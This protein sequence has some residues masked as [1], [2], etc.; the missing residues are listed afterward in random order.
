MYFNSSIWILLRYLLQFKLTFKVADEDKAALQDVTIKIKDD[1]GLIVPLKTNAE[2]EVK[3]KLKYPAGTKLTVEEVS[4]EGYVLADGTTKEITVSSIESE[5]TIPL[6]L[7]IKT[8]S[9]I[10]TTLSIID[11]TLLQVLFKVI[12]KNSEGQTLGAGAT[13]EVEDLNSKIEVTTTT[14]EDST[15]LND[16]TKFKVG[17]MVTITVNK[18]GY[19]AKKSSYTFEDKPGPQE[20]IVSLTKEVFGEILSCRK[21]D[22]NLGWTSYNLKTIP[23]ESTEDDCKTSCKLNPDCDYYVYVEATKKCWCGQYSKSSPT[24]DLNKLPALVTLKY[25]K[26]KISTI[27]KLNI[28]LKS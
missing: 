25:K 21:Q 16:N 5:R 22:N 1:E 10:L 11:L 12:I 28:F 7:N 6:Q 20:L 27:L 26:G 15:T 18:D 13:V 9:L 19:F 3:T 17:S 23:G 8:V 2:G 14:G 24:V 4:K